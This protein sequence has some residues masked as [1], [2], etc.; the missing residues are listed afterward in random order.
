MTLLFALM[1]LGVILGA[2]SYAS[3]PVFLIAA[4]AIAAWLLVFFVRERTGHRE[5]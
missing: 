5:R 2:V 3:T 1:A 4:A